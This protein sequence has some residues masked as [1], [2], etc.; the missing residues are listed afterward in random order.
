MK[1]KIIL[2]TSSFVLF[3]FSAVFSQNRMPVID[4]VLVSQNADNFLV[5]IEYGAHDPDADTLLILVKVS[6]DGGQTFNVPAYS[7][8]GAY[9]L[10]QS[11]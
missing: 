1:R 10:G 5:E 8:S 2:L 11:G 4:T 7:F 3:A 6:N 9:G